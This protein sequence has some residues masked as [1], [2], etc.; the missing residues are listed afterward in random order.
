L[1][2]DIELSAYLEKQRAW[3]QATARPRFEW[4]ATIGRLVL[5][6]E[7]ALARAWRRHGAKASGPAA[8][9]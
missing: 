9:L 6:V 2:G 3:R 5:S 8:L 1:R 7:R 4:V